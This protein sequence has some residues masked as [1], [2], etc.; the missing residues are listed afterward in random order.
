MRASASAGWRADRVLSWG[1]VV[2]AFAEGHLDAYAIS[3]DPA[4]PE[5][6]EIR[7]VPYVGVEARLPLIRAAGAA[8]QVLEPVAQL[9]L[10]P[11]RRGAV[12]NEDSLTPELDEGNLLSTGRFAGRDRRESGDRVNVGLSYARLAPAAGLAVD[13]F[14][15]RVLRA[16]DLDQFSTGTGLDGDRSDWLVSVAARRGERLEVLGRSLF[17]DDLEVSRFD[18]ILRWRGDRHA[19]E[20]RYTFLEADAEAGRGRT[21]SELFVDAGYDLTRDWT[22]RAKWRYDFEADDPSRAGV[23]LTYRS[24]CVTVALDVERRFTATDTLEPTTR[25]GLAVELAGFGTDDGPRR[26]RRCGT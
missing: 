16:A 14:A 5:D 21:T 11:G 22:G 24:D 1:A 12:P 6:R 26:R 18:S 25:F 4:F 23:G 13:A 2:A 8:T 9:V 17:D 10:A 19:L 7:F 20:S 3:Q 15:G